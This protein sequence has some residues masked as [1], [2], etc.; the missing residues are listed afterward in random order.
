MKAK[1]EEGESR[2]KGRAS[3]SKTTVYLRDKAEK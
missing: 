2:S 3:G 1:G